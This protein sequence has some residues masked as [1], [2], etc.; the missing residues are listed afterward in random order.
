MAEADEPF[1]AFITAVSGVL[2]HAQDLEDGFM[3][4]HEQFPGQFLILDHASRE[5]CR[6]CGGDCAPADHG[7]ID[8]FTR[9]WRDDARRITSRMRRSRPIDFCGSSALPQRRVSF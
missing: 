8:A 6:N 9:R 4:A 5:L 3:F 2:H 7:V 1:A